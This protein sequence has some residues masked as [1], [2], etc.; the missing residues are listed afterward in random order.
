LTF[1]KNK[2]QLSASVCFFPQV[3]VI[4]EIHILTPVLAKIV[5]YVAEDGVDALKPLVKAGPVFKTVMYSKKN[6]KLC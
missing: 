3:A 2:N 6:T 4:L 5:S 1:N